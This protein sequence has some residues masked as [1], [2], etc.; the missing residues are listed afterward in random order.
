MVSQP[1]RH[2][3]TSLL[4]TARLV[5]D[6]ERSHRPTEIVDVH[7]QIRHRFVMPP[8]LAETV[9]L[10][11]LSGVAMPI[12]RVLTLHERRI[13]RPAHPDILS[14]AVTAA[15]VPK[16]TRVAIATT[17]PFSRVFSTTA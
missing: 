16:T 8:V 11:G 7:R 9:R 13:D 10:A 1:G 17:R 3:R 6:T 12:R 2:C 4:P 14:A 15:I 5:L